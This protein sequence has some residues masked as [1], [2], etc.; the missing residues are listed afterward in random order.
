MKISTMAVSC[1]L[2]IF[3]KFPW[4]YSK[5][6]ALLEDMTM[7]LAQ[8]TTVHLDELLPFKRAFLSAHIIEVDSAT[9]SL[10][11]SCSQN[12]LV[13]LATL[14]AITRLNLVISYWDAHCF[15]KIFLSFL[16][17]GTIQNILSLSPKS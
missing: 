10:V 9:H 6:I 11:N 4:Q 8:L 3:V 5:C 16:K 14:C 12:G 7:F 15:V 1:I 2:K 17:Q 13:F